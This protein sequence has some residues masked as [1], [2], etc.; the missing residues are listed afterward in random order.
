MVLRYARGRRRGAAGWTRRHVVVTSCLAVACVRLWGEV[1]L[2]DRSVCVSRRLVT[3]FSHATDRET[4]QI[5]TLHVPGG[6][7]NSSS[8]KSAVLVRFMYWLL[9]RRA[10]FSTFEKHKS[11][12]HSFFI[13][14]VIFFVSPP[15]C[16][17]SLAET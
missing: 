2:Y 12:S 16:Y 6:C 5:V 9:A 11:T 13:P 7:D 4:S 17:R 8:L 10:V 14:S 3:S 1:H 15:L